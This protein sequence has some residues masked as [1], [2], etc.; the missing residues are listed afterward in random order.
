MYQLQ[1]Y[2]E[3]EIR[4]MLNVSEREQFYYTEEE[5]RLNL[6]RGDRD[7]CHTL[8]RIGASTTHCETVDMI[9][10]I[11]AVQ[12]VVDHQTIYSPGTDAFGF[13]APDSW[14]VPPVRG[15]REKDQALPS[16]STVSGSSKQR[17]SQSSTLT[18]TFKRGKA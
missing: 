13:P 1:V 18:R 17:A 3:G 2:K 4:D 11:D 15:L 9:K 8:H 16:S 7:V 10:K 6:D 14:S 5:K 12:G